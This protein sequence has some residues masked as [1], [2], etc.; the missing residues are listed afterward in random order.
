MIASTAA[1]SFRAA[2]TALEVMYRAGLRVSEVVR[3]APSDIRWKDG[4]LEAREGKRAK[5]RNVPVDQETV[6]WLR[7]AGPEV[8]SPSVTGTGP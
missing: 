4:I 8:S 7:R 3:L 5:G 1:S 2:A 6:V